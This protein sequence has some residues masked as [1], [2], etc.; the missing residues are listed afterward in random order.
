M[1]TTLLS[2][3]SLKAVTA[4]NLRLPDYAA[5]L[6][7][8]QNTQ[9]PM[10]WLFVG[11]SITHGVEHTHGRRSY[12]EL[13]REVLTW[14]L[15]LRNRKGARK[16]DIVINCGVAGETAMGFRKA[17]PW[18]LGQ[19][20]PHV[21]FISFGV[22]DAGLRHDIEIFQADLK[23]IV[24]AVRETEAIPVLQTPTPTRDG[25]TSRP[26]YAEAVRR[27]AD[28]SSV[29]LIDHAAY[30]KDI[31]GSDEAMEEWMSDE[32][33]PNEEGHCAMM[34]V[35]ATELDLVPPHSR[36]TEGEA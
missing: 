17:M 20:L 22:N 13:W 8:V 10:L 33:H 2:S 28:E 29:L 21:V 23:R 19:F 24:A 14:E 12:V 15:S 6:E 7:R 32:L 25:L 34:K 5:L 16:D 9:Q 36:T 3:D 1:N 18:R 26:D 4:R 31:S 30:W 27:A 35:L 11:D